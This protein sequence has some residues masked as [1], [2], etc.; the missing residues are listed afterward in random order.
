VAKSPKNKNKPGARAAR[1]R[2]W[3]KLWLALTVLLAILVVCLVYGFWASTFDLHQVQEMAER[4]T[5]FDMDGKVYSRLQGENRVTVKLA[6]VSPYFIK[7]LLSREDSRFYQHHGVDPFGILRAVF[8]NLT[9][10]AAK[11]GAST[12]TQQLAR[13]SFPEGLG[14]RKSIHRKILEAFVAVRIEQNYTKDQILEAYVNR[15]YFGSTV[16]GIETASQTYFGTHAANLSL[17]EAALIAG[18]IRAPTYFSPLKNLKGALHERDTV[19]ERM[20]KQGQITDADAARAK[21]TTIVLAKKRP[22]STQDN[23]AMDM[24]RRELDELLTDEQRQDGGMKIY[25]TLDPALQK[26]SESAVDVELTKIE[27]RPGYKHPR[28]ADFSAQA[29]AEEQD[30][31]YLQGALM[32][33]DNRSGGIRAIVGGRDFSESKY[34]RAIP[35]KPSRQIGSTF[36]PFVYAAAFDKGILPG[37]AIDD[38]PIARGEIRQAANWSPE[39]S[40]GTYKGLMRAEEGLIQS[41]NTMSVRVGERAGLPEIARVAAAAGIENIPHVPAVYLGAFEASVGDLTTAYTV[42]ANNGVRHQSYVIERID[43]A[44]GETIY[45]AAHIQSAAL[46]PGVAWM[47]TSTM[48]KVIERGTAA[49]AKS[50]GF[51]KPAA[52]KTGTT[53]DFHDAWFVGY[54]TALT[55]GVWVGLDKPETIMAHGYGAALAL[56]IWTDVMKAASPQRY[57]ANEFR[58]TVPLRRVTVCSV[59]NELATTSCEHSGT[60]YTIDLPESRIP[61][62]P[63]QV[64]QGSVLAQDEPNGD[65]QKRSLP[66]SIFRSFRKFFGGE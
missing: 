9:H 12:I 8:R 7:A 38:G 1:S 39:N 50:L 53:N 44:A 34:N 41:R 49:S 66:Q 63:C 46:D 58:P 18:L 29:K 35:V 15:I 47:L 22:T 30:T 2:S 65:T 61:R 3:W 28:K 6:Q 10:G 55:C 42:F 14:S 52:G 57:P 19:L 31:P 27:A 23:Y 54:T 43:D 59:S 25:T 26:A 36:K 62:D 32:V 37:M 40:D 17:G 20:V 45:R 56:P 48:Q 21:S 51:T 13:N 16:Y 4:S 33:I 5:V 64:H 11:E 24:V 60:A